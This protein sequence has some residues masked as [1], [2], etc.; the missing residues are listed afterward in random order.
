MKFLGAV[1]E[2][3]K[4]LKQVFKKKKESVPLVRQ[5]KGGSFIKIAVEKNFFMIKHQT[6][7]ECSEETSHLYC[8][9]MAGM[10]IAA[11]AVNYKR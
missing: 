1:L 9:R 3:L 6:G 4:S 2:V 7:I 10:R 8:S 5:W 11:S